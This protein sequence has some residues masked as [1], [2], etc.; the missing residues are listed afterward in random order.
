[1]SDL[2]ERLK[3]ILIG[4]GYDDDSGLNKPAG[5]VVRRMLVELRDNPTALML[6][7]LA[8]AMG[9][10]PKHHEYAPYAWAAAIDEVLDE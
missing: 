5:R 10:T 8:D 4:A 6:D 2:R 9:D 1:M 7:H 3:Q